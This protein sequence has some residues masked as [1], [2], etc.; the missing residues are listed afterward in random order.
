MMRICK[1]HVLIHQM[2]YL[3]WLLG[4]DEEDDSKDAVPETTTEAVAPTEPNKRRQPDVFICEKCKQC[5][6]QKR[7]SRSKRKHARK[8]HKSIN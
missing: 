2:S 5:E 4:Y 1:K 8:Q 6:F 3:Y 7:D